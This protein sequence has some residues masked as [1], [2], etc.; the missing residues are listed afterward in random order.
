MFQTMYDIK[1]HNYVGFPK[2]RLLICRLEVNRP[3]YLVRTVRSVRAN[4]LRILAD[5]NNTVCRIER[6]SPAL[7]II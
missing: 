4:K 7:T 3:L 1:L 2:L 5:L 6:G